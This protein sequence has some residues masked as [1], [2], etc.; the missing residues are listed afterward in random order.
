MLREGNSLLKL[1]VIMMALAL[2]LVLG[3]VV[4]S[5][6]LRSEPERVVAAQVA[7]K[8]LA[9]SRVTPPASKAVRLRSLIARRSPPVTPVGRRRWGTTHPP[10]VG[11]WA[12]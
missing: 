5:A 7:T 1:G 11:R 2:A 4:V 12:A 8:S 3:G 6:T 10:L 9:K